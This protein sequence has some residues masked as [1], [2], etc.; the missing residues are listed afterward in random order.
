MRNARLP[1]LALWTLALLLSEACASPTPGPVAVVDGEPIRAEALADELL[2]RFPR[3]GQAVAEAQRQPAAVEFIASLDEA[4]G[5]DEVERAMDDLIDRELVRQALEREGVLIAE[6]EV[7]AWVERS[8]GRVEGDP[9]YQGAPF[10]QILA[11]R[12]RDIATF[13]ADARMRLGLERLASVE[14]GP[15]TE[16]DLRRHF[17]RHRHWFAGGSAHIRMILRD[18]T[19][20]ADPEAARREAQDLLARTRDEIVAGRLSFEEAARRYSDDPASAADGGDLGVLSTRAPYPAA[21]L[22]AAFV[23]EPGEVSPPVDTIFGVHLVLVVAYES[24][25]PVTFEAVRE[26]VFDDLAEE[27]AREVLLGLRAAADIL[28]A[29]PRQ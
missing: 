7:R 22:R 4:I 18:T 13:E 3:H 21:L 12:H 6:A 25:P 1:V 2:H 26:R 27:R 11:A 29:V 17:E 10:E 19:A 14:R 5:T 24:A 28:R 8:R 15:I 20:A 9:I 23:L 16:A